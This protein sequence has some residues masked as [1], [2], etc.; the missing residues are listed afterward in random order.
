MIPQSKYLLDVLSNNDV[1]FYIPPYQRNYEWEL[2]QCEVFY[3]DILKVAQERAKGGNAEHF[4]GTITYFQ[5]GGAFGQTAELVLIDGQQRITT[6]MLFLVAL[7]DICGDESIQKF[8]NS[9]YLIN[10]NATDSNEYKIKLKQVESDWGTYCNIILGREISEQDKESAVYKN[11][12]F[13]V[14]KLSEEKQKNFPRLVELIEK[15]LSLFSVVT[16]QLEPERNPWENPQEIFESMNSLGKPLSLGDLVRNYILLGKAPKIQEALYSKYWLKIETLLP[17]HVSRYIHDYMQVVGEKYYLKAAENNYKSLYASFK[18]MFAD[19]DSETLLDNLATYADYY[20]YAALGKSCGNSRI[21]DRLADIRT[22]GASTATSFLMGLLS[23]WSYKRLSDSDMCDILDVFLIYLIRRRI[24]GISGSENKNFPQLNRKIPDLEGSI[25]KKDEFFR[26]LS[27]QESIMRLPND[28]EVGNNLSMMN[29]YNFRYSKFVLAMVEEHITKARPTGS[30][31]VLQIE[32]IMPQTLNDQWRIALG[33]NCEEI[34]TQ[35]VNTIGN[36]TLIRHNQELGNRPFTEKKKIY[37]EKAGLQIAKT[38]IT[39]QSKWN[40]KAIEYRAN[41]MI[42]MLLDEI[43][44]LPRNMKR[45][46]NYA[47]NSLGRHLSFDDLQLVGET[48][49]YIKDKSITAKVV[50]DTEVEFEDK[51]WHL[52][53]LTREIETRKGTA[54]SSGAYQGAQYWEFD[55]IKLADIM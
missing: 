7:R 28:I 33:K 45:R 44:P 9:K 19:Y 48:I 31:D 16:V 41:W 18:E 10:S 43:L 6:T 21:D 15:G 40:K 55:G 42:N 23:S 50:S 14:E 11:Y 54:N 4:F 46:N 13:F 53:T 35:Y 37:E 32:H 36:L 27:T 5:N 12:M 38:L 2:A 29:F 8:I 20:A 30:G 51:K 22:L 52:A 26:I 47:S 39:D 34:H 3:N 49:N 25:S 24:I 1:T 17:N